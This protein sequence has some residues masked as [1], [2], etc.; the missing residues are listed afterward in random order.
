[1]GSGDSQTILQDRFLN[2]LLIEASNSASSSSLP[3]LIHSK[4][5]STHISI[6]NGKYLFSI[7]HNVI[8]YKWMWVQT[9]LNGW[10]RSSKF[11]LQYRFPEN[12]TE[13]LSKGAATCTTLTKLGNK[14]AAVQLLLTALYQLNFDFWI[15]SLPCIF[16]TVLCQQ[17][18]CRVYN[19]FFSYPNDS[20]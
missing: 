2:T 1:M 8:S 16:I 6:L 3:I 19:T 14:I 15:G 20:A 11:S 13:W 4:S 9:F 7:K 12:T 10:S 18:E 17:N 5:I